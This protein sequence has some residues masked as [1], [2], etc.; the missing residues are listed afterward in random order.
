MAHQWNVM[1]KRFYIAL[2]STDEKHQFNRELNQHSQPARHCHPRPR[3]GHGV[4]F[5]PAI[6]S[7]M[8]MLQANQA[9]L[10]KR[11]LHRDELFS[12]SDLGQGKLRTEA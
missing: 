5:Q 2:R 3:H 11:L 1:E 7:T 10:A 9:N 4:A 6:D 12:T 8:D